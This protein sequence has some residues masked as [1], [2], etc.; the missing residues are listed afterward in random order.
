MPLQEI[1]VI[2]DIPI[3]RDTLTQEATPP[4]RQV[5]GGA[6]AVTIPNT[7]L[8]DVVLSGAESNVTLVLHIT[9]I[10]IKTLTKNSPIT[11]IRVNLQ[12]WRINK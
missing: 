4:D 2:I 1:Q 11:I 5:R 10:R 3:T 9:L 8:Q 6:D 12:L 7:F